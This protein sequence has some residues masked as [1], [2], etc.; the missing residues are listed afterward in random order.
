[1]LK[2][3]GTNKKSKMIMNNNNFIIL[4]FFPVFIVLNVKT[5]KSILFSV[6]K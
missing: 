1:M 6:T 3:P 5:N 2:N 4:V